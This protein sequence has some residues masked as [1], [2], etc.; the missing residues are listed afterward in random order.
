MGNLF[1]KITTDA[2]TLEDELNCDCSQS[3]AQVYNAAQR[4]TRR[5]TTNNVYIGA[6]HRSRPQNKVYNILTKSHLNLRGHLLKLKKRSAELDIGKIFL[7]FSTSVIMFNEEITES[8]YLS[9]FKRK[10]YYNC[11][12]LHRAL[13]PYR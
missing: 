12:K 5:P 2:G 4:R 10:P 9:A 3:P 13:S 7:G 8:N 6:Q 11:V 1:G